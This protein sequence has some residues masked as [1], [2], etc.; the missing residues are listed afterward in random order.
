VVC[1][2]SAHFFSS[3]GQEERSD[4]GEQW[5]WFILVSAEF[6]AGIDKWMLKNVISSVILDW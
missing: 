2:D 5:F 4:L 6:C 1:F 3:Q